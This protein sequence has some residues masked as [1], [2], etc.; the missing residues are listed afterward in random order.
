MTK[1][2]E[3]LFIQKYE[4]LE[5]ELEELRVRFIVLQQENFELVKTCKTQKEFINLVQL[6]EYSSF[7]SVDGMLEKKDISEELNRLL[8]GLCCEGVK[9]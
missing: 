1:T 5:K 3:E 2:L 7:F 6:K 8:S 9:E 4:K